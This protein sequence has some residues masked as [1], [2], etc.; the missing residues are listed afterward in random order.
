M[1]FS[2]SVWWKQI[3]AAGTQ[4]QLLVGLVPNFS[5]PM[6]LWAPTLCLA[7]MIACMH[8][9]SSAAAETVFILQRL[10]LHLPL[11]ML[12]E[13]LMAWQ[14]AS[15]TNTYFPAR[16]VSRASTRCSANNWEPHQ[17]GCSCLRTEGLGTICSGARVEGVLAWSQ[18]FFFWGGG[19]DKNHKRWFYGV[20][21]GSMQTRPC[22]AGPLQE[23]QISATLALQPCLT[24]TVVVG[25]LGLAQ[26]D[27]NWVPRACVLL[28]LAESLR[29]GCCFTMWALMPVQLWS[30]EVCMSCSKWWVREGGVGKS[31]LPKEREEVASLCVWLVKTHCITQ[32][33]SQSPLATWLVCCSCLFSIG[34]CSGGSSAHIGLRG[35]PYQVGWYRAVVKGESKQRGRRRPDSLLACI[36]PWQL[37]GTNPPDHA[38]GANRCEQMIPPPLREQ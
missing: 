11:P 26:G 21:V 33:G 13:G 2:V 1:I 10:F 16:H 30:V 15:T 34:H 28:L 29:A 27:G 9:S 3:L 35:I 4:C 20:S 37:P 25:Y 38:Y 23:R 22:L 12:Q 32:V 14:G 31:C 24:F 6:W 8:A 19:A 18:K 5:Q 17:S 7:Q 36:H